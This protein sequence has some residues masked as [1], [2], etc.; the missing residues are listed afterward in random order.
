MR[1]T[2]PVV[3]RL[4]AYTKLGGDFSYRNIV[5][6]TNPAKPHAKHTCVCLFI[7]FYQPC[8]VAVAHG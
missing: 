3:N 6:H 5:L 1:P 4:S 7:Y 2:E 8:A